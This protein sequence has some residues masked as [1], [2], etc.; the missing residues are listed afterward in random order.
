[1]AF[2]GREQGGLQAG[3]AG[4]SDSGPGDTA[5]AHHASTT[6]VP[7]PA[8][9]PA[10]LLVIKACSTHLK[11]PGP[12]QGEVQ[13]QNFLE[14]TNPRAHLLDIQPPHQ[15]PV[16]SPSLPTWPAEPRCARA[17]ASCP[18]GHRGEGSARTPGVGAQGAGD[19]A[20][21]ASRDVG[22][23]G[24]RGT[25]VTVPSR[26]GSPHPGTAQPQGGRAG[27][28]VLHRVLSGFSGGQH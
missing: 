20:A 6:G 9:V 11:E 19:Y 10:A 28:Q 24:A 18:R 15:A 16:S 13:G 27:G 7:P 17:P 26:R 2:L 25:P 14:A 1:M 23:L 3:S 8:S 22:R 12:R 21:G 4:L 5:T